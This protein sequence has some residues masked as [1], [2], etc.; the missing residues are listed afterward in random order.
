M[1]SLYDSKDW[2]LQHYPA[3][4]QLFEQITSGYKNPFAMEMNRSPVATQQDHL[5]SNQTSRFKDGPYSQLIY[6]ALISVEDHR[7]MVPDICN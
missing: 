4:T 5:K 2:S 7:M 3:P 1:T 6:N